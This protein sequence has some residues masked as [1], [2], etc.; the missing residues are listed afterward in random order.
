MKIHLMYHDVFESNIKESGF[1]RK[2]DYP[3]KIS[4]HSFEEQIQA[5][6]TFCRDKGICQD[7]VVFTF[8]DGG[9]SFYNVVAPILERYG[10][11][12][13]FFISTQYID[14]DTFLSKQE[15]IALHKRGHI[16]GSHAHSHKHLYSLTD[17]QVVNEWKNS[18][19][20]LS[21]ILG[22]R[23]RYASIPNGDVSKRVLNAISLQ[24]VQY[25]Y[26]SEPTVFVKKRDKMSIIGRYVILSESSTEYV[27]SLVESKC[28][29][30]LLLMRHIV[31]MPIKKILGG[32]YVKLKNIFYK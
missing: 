11:Q 6:A 22:E 2:R 17:E 25:V 14:T 29:R 28:R 12:G 8:D 16:I 26:T 10:Y 21:D 32:Y 5:I 1:L 20:I 3:Y 4:A 7:D 30:N 24:G 13:M 23:I 9:K 15:I 31:L 19:D 27:L 18:I